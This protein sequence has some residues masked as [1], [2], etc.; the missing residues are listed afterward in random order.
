M[1]IKPNTSCANPLCRRR[2]AAYVQRYNSPTAVKARADAA[3]TAAKQ[4]AAPVHED[5][6]W[7]IE[8]V[9]DEAPPPTSAA[10]QELA[11]GLQ[12]ELPV[13]FLSGHFLLLLSNLVLVQAGLVPDRERDA[14]HGPKTMKSPY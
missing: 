2:Q 9:N 8:V 4:Q 11:P 13:R 7:K 1:N 14:A 10:T 12:Y 3:E 5:N 6:E